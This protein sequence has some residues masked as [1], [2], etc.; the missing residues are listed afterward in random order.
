MTVHRHLALR[1]AERRHFDHVEQ[2]PQAGLA[3]VAQLEVVVK[4]YK[5]KNK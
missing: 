5:N 1:H 2:R 3:V 4:Y